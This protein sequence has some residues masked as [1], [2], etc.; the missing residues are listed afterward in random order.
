MKVIDHPVRFKYGTRVL[1]L[2]GRN[3]DG[4]TDQ[5]TLMRISHDAGQFEHRLAE[6]QEVSRPAERIYASAGPRAVSAAMRVFKE[7]QL[8]ADYDEDPEAFYRSIETRW[9][10][11]LMAPRAQDGKVW[12]FD[13]DE[14]N[15][16]ERVE[17][18]LAKQY[19]RD[20]QP[21]R[22]ATKSGAHIVV[23]PFNKSLLSDD[24]RALIHDNPLMLWG[25]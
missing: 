11:C 1:F 7:R 9:A 17:A 25:Y 12:L 2:K 6:L 8:A 23:A 20:V 14:P 19:D 24:V 5:R 18:E 3:K 10:S 22:Y 15:D 16:T 4:C 21:Y 13:C